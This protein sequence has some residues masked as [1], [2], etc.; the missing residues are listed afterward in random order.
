[1]SM[2]EKY[3]MAGRIDSLGGNYL[4]GVDVVFMVMVLRIEIGESILG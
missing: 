2:D 3:M 1:M 4:G